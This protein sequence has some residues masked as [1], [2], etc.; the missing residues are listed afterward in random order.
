VTTRRRSRRGNHR[1]QRGYDDIFIDVVDPSPVAD[2]GR[3]SLRRLRASCDT[4]VP[5]DAR[6]WLR[7]VSFL[8]EL[9]A[10]D[11]RH[12]DKKVNTERYHRLVDE[13]HH[14]VSMGVWM[15]AAQLTGL[16]CRVVDYRLRRT[17]NG[18][19]HRENHDDQQ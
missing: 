7:A 9:D 17:G 11:Q 13:Q 12:A 10:L 5:K 4:Y 15:A 6:D 2:A 16:A 14:A 1:P 19:R 18:D 3:D 8:R